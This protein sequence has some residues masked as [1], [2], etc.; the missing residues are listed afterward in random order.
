MRFARKHVVYHEI[1]KHDALNPEVIA[2]IILNTQS[3][4]DLKSCYAKA[5]KEFQGNQAALAVIEDAKNK[6]KA[7][8]MEIK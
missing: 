5:F 8:L 6:R 3:M 4:D 7:E 1:K 2:Q